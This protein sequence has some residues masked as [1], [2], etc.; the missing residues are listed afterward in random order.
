M[1]HEVVDQPYWLSLR[2]LALF[3]CW[4]DG[5]FTVQTVLTCPK[6]SFIPRL[7]RGAM[8]ALSVFADSLAGNLLRAATHREFF[9]F[10][11]SPMIA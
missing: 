10:C 11:S 1:F 2:T 6:V 5:K 9:A 3:H 4:K 7:L 8:P